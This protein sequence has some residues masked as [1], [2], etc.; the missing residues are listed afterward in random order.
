MLAK[1]NTGNEEW[2]AE[3][4]MYEDIF[5][6]RTG[7]K[8]NVIDIVEEDELGYTSKNGDIHLAES[9]R[10]MDDM[11]SGEKKA[12]RQGVFCHEMLHQIY[13]DFEHLEN[14]L[15]SQ[16]GQ[17]RSI[18]SLFANLVEDPAIEHLA[19][20]VVGGSV[21]KSLNY[22]IRAIYDKS[23][24]ITDNTP[25]EQLCNGLIQFGDMG[26]IK[27]KMSDEV[28]DYFR[29][30]A[31]DFNRLIESS[32]S[33]D[34]IDMAVVWAE[35]TK[36]LWKK[37]ENLDE[38]IKNIQGNASSQMDGPSDNSPSEGKTSPQ[39][40]TEDAASERRRNFS[41]DMENG[42]MPDEIFGEVEEENILTASDLQQIIS[43]IYDNMD[44][45]EEEKAKNIK[46]E[47]P[48]DIQ[49][50]EYSGTTCRNIIMEAENR[51]EY[52]KLLEK[53]N[54]KIQQLTW[55]L[56]KIFLNDV[57]TEIHSTSGRYNIKRGL[58]E[59]SVKVFDKRKE[60]RNLLDLSVTILVD[61]S[62][63]M[64]TKNRIEEARNAA[65]ILTETFAR[66]NIPCCVIGFTADEG[67]SDI[68]HRHFV[69]FKNRAVERT[70]LADMQAYCNNFDGYSI[71]YAG[72][73]AKRYQSSHKILF[74][75][76]DGQP[77]CQ[78][79]QNKEKGLSDTTKAIIEVGRSITV[80]GIG[81]GD[82]EKIFQKMYQGRFVA[83]TPDKLPQE[84]SKQLKKI[85]LKL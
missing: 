10:L 59:D 14:V 25:F 39:K 41:K 44:P 21:L 72:R 30:I 57:D 17:Q 37:E 82:N 55:S 20:E 4:R 79:Y 56:K 18:T 74:V 43:Q 69:S 1:R 12:F 53:L 42:D 77:S 23:P 33:R 22:S 49:M 47:M 38:T 52:L 11:S 75:I 46:P 54:K 2:V 73:L 13:T 16:K 62:G 8:T 58:K 70:S 27:G 66:L 51:E 63:S 83:T 6:S 36:P 7:R 48:P 65:I 5:S 24:E 31:P 85:I 28:K 3:K 60:K 84:L 67:E 19:P 78:N 35:M 26:I 68:T 80:M 71:R 40:N 34:R 9:H 32:S 15:D 29:K 45:Y 50:P 64:R 81:I 76:S 61:Q